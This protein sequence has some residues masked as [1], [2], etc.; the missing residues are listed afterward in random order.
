MYIGNNLSTGRSETYVKTA[1]GSE[2]TVTTSDDGRLINYTVGWVK[3]WLNGVLLVNG[4]DYTATSGSSITGLTALSTNDVLTIESQHMFSSDDSV[5][6]TGGTFSG[7]V[8]HTGSITANG[9]FETATNK[10][11]QQKG[12]FMQSSTH[13]SLVLGG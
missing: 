13:Q 1:S 9:G 4:T 8:T 12:A 3:V 2:T 10:K 11:I 6:A 7:N 5:P